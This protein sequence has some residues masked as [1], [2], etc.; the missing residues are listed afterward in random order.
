MARPC[1]Q[2]AKESLRSLRVG[3]VAVDTCQRCHGLWFGRGQ[4][5]GLAD[6]PPV[7]VFLE[8]ARG[9]PSC[10]RGG[11]HRVPEERRVCPTCQGAPLGCPACG[12]RLARVTT[13]ACELDVCPRC[14]GVW[15]DAAGF[16]R[17]EGVTS[18]P[19]RPPVR[20]GAGGLACAA[21]GVVVRG[22][23]AFAHQGDPYCARCR[24][25]GAVMLDG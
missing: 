3:P 23:R 8:A 21:C 1:P 4:W 10:C 11:G 22:A 9:A 17:L 14:E 25:P 18:L 13:S 5:D 24:P 7:R 6:R 16:A 20:A 15:V 12:E 2:C 19:P